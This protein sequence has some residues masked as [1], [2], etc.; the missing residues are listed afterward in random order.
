LVNR[1]GTNTYNPDL[2][3]GLQTTLVDGW[4]CFPNP[5]TGILAIEPPNTYLSNYSVSITA[6]DGRL[7]RTYQKLNLQTALSVNDLLPGNY[8]IEL[9]SDDG[10]FRKKF[11]KQ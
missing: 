2:T 8:W 7:I 6:M 1:V 11:I 5:V 9:K 3:V 4:K 10:F